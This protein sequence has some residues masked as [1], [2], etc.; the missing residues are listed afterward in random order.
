MGLTVVTSAGNINVTTA[1]DVLSSAPSGWDEQITEYGRGANYPI[2][3]N[4]TTVFRANDSSDI[5]ANIFAPIRASNSLK[6]KNSLVDF[7][8]LGNNNEFSNTLRHTDDLGTTIYAN[9]LLIDHFTGLM[10]DITTYSDSWANAIDN[11]AS[12]TFGGYSDWF[13]PSLNQLLSIWKLGNSS[14]IGVNYAPFTGTISNFTQIT[15]SSTDPAPT[16]NSIYLRAAQGAMAG[17]AKTTI[18]FQ[19]RCRKYL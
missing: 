18:T 15:T 17:V 16:T 3:D 2:P 19:F 14:D 5:E 9:N 6:V 11:A 8:T 7:D 1:R 12:S 13:V 4:Q 10:W